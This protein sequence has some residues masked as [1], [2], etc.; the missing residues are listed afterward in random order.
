[1]NYPRMM[2]ADTLEVLLAIMTEAQRDRF[3]ER[4]EYDMSFSIPN[5]GRYR[6]NAYKQR[7]SVAMAFRLVGTKVPAPEELGV[8]VS[9]VDLYQ[10]KR[11]LVLVTGPTGSGCPR[12]SFWGSS[13]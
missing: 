5:V 11:G 13:S 6:V 12:A 4:G 8:P 2:P 3:E 1:M 7:G 10:R 9:V